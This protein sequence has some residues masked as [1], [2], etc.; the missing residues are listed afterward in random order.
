M[1]QVKPLVV[2][3]L[4]VSGG[5]TGVCL[6]QTPTECSGD[7]AAWT[8]CTGT[9]ELKDGRKYVGEFRNGLFDGKGTLTWKD[10]DQ[11]T[12]EFKAGVR[13]GTGTVTLAKIAKF[14]GRWT[15]GRYAGP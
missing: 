12:G 4:L 1:S 10:G 2:T 14:S 3:A 6:G 5:L 7:V 11:Y 8:D 13:E 9:Q 15:N